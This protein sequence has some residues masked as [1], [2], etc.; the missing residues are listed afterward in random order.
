M[1]AHRYG[2]CRFSQCDNHFHWEKK[3]E[4]FHCNLRHKDFV[5]PCRITN[6]LSITAED[7]IAS[8]FKFILKVL[9]GL[10]FFH[11]DKA[12]WPAFY[13]CV[14]LPFSFAEPI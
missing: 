2:S 14:F 3:D 7:L 5:F 13:G 9:I 12:K 4:T 10:E 8:T 11:D 1:I 6:C